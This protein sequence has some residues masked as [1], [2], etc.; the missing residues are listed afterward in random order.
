MAEGA[1]K[2]TRRDHMLDVESRMQAIWEEERL[3]E[4]EPTP[5]KD[6]FMVTFPYPYMN[7]L[8]HLG[9]AFTLSKAEFAAG[10]HRVKGE[11]V[12]FPFA[13]HCTGM[14]I[15]AAANKLKRALE[16][17]AAGA[18]AGEEGGE[19]DAGEEEAGKAEEGGE[20]GASAAAVGKSSR[21]KLV[22]KTGG[23]KSTAAILAMMG[24]PE[25]EIPSFADPVHWLQYFPP[26]ARRDLKRF[27]CGID[28]RRSFITTDVNP[29]YDAF[30]R[31]QFRKLKEA[32]R[33]KFGKRPTVY[34]PLDGQ[35]CMDHDRASGEGSGP[36]EYT[37]I[38][39]RVA[40]GDDGTLPA[41]LSE[42]AGHAVF[43][44]AATLR[45]ET[46]YGQTNCFVLPSGEYGAFEVNE[47][48]DVFICS[49]RSA[50][51]MSYQGLGPYG[52]PKQLASYTGQQLLGLPL[53]APLATYEVVYTLPLLTISMG[54]GTGV[55]T[56]VPSD[57][58]DDYAAL[59]DLQRK[60]ALREKFG[61]AEEW[62]TYDVVPIIDIPDLGTQA[63]VTLCDQLGIV[64]QND[65]AKLDEAK[66]IAYLR[67]FTDGVL[68]VGPHAGTKV[69][70]A[71]AL[72][73]ADMIE[74]GLAAPY[75]E[76]ENRV[77]SRSG[78]EC[79]IAFVDQ[80][81]LTYGADSWRDSVLAHVC[82]DD[83]NAHGDIALGEYKTT[84]GWLKEWACS[85][86]FGLGTKVPWDEQFV[87]ESLSDST[88]Y[89]AYY[90]ISH[91]LQGGVLD[92]SEVGPAGIA[93]ADVDD[94]MFDAVF[95]GKDLPEGHALSAD[96]LE[97]MRASFN[98]FYPM[99]LR[100]SGKDLIKNHLTMALYNHASIWEGKPQYWPRGYYTNG[101]IMVDAEKMSKSK[102]NFLT[103]SQ[104][105]DQ[106]SAD[107]ARFAMAD[108]GDTMDDAN[109]AVS[110]ANS[111]I[112]RLT[113]E[114]EWVKTT[115]AA[116]DAGELRAADSEHNWVDRVLMAEMNRCIVR[117]DDR[118]NRMLFREA[119]LAGFYDLQSAR[120]AYRTYCRL[121]DMKMHAG[122]LRRFMDVQ[123]ALLAP[124]CPHWSECI[125]RELLGNE[126]SALVG[127]WPEAAD[128]DAEALMQSDFLVASLK[129][130]RQT[131]T[132]K[133]KKKKGKKK[134]G[135]A[136]PEGPPNHGI[137]YTGTFE[138]WQ[139]DVLTVLRDASEGKEDDAA[140]VSF[141][142]DIMKTLKDWAISA[143]LNVKKTM[144]FASF[145]KAA[146]LRD[147]AS[148]LNAEAA[149]SEVAFLQ[150][151]TVYIAAAL[152]L[153]S[154]EVWE[155]GAEDAPK[156]AGNT[157]KN[158]CPGAPTITPVFK[159]AA[160]TEE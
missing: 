148:A 64:S 107:A 54:K 8:L 150:E 63:A 145:M 132:R 51:N 131:L 71:K 14:P 52:K 93:A 80:W 67:G 156:P 90:T 110:V 114:E 38:K 139:K 34:S 55:V 141:P 57:A 43:L 26:L 88:I 94:A 1:P 130:W 97:Q 45:P 142:D 78:D 151:H 13:F 120:D 65:R 35:A 17:A 92:G 123:V 53:N 118:Y 81:Y 25:E 157:S 95:L 68:L 61:I 112:L 46:M 133:T 7:G 82:S 138:D 108:A 121:V 87:I 40:V 126:G 83:F 75:W 159:P 113:T 44:V 111:A 73:R 116:I 140:A 60:P 117:A 31:W 5:G 4:A 127:S 152:D 19:A 105:I 137:I 104:A 135:D 122:V 109:Y 106:F 42:L 129:T 39:L 49:A 24:I 100:V 99:D 124:I 47:A 50:L 30:I 10:Y 72:V 77:V 144:Q 20:G 9:H 160:A 102:G 125:W 96:M 119:L 56:S 146:A 23:V 69:S 155:A 91:L 66:H 149:F 158:A 154:V 134:G 2:T 84:L 128:I 48:G 103:L 33:I 12:L 28:M 41:V 86:S 11:T 15:Q 37:L 59:R 143:R 27:G 36:Q 89:M 58:P 70:D 16:L 22:A 18:A 21:S 29:Y 136:A 79:V 62:V 147:G 101:H 85:R 76:P 6:K 153:A 98:Y 74:A 3:F 32:G 115:L